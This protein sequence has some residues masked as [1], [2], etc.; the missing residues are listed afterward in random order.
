MKEILI[1]S[2][3]GVER[4]KLREKDTNPHLG[5]HKQYESRNPSISRDNN[6]FRKTIPSTDIF[7]FSWIMLIKIDLDV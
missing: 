5:S 7:L 2:S 6:I 1:F 3:A 4:Y